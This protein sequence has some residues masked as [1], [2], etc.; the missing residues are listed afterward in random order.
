MTSFQLGVVKDDA[1]STAQTPDGVNIRKINY[2]VLGV[3]KTPIDSE[4]AKQEFRQ[5][6]AANAPPKV[7]AVSTNNGSTILLSTLTSEAGS[8]T[9]V[10]LSATT[11]TTTTAS[12]TTSLEVLL[13]GKLA[14]ANATTQAEILPPAPLANA[15]EGSLLMK[16]YNP[17][18]QDAI[19]QTLQQLWTQAL[20]KLLRQTCG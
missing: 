13:T 5:L 18:D 7:W 17:T 14:P 6:I 11:L 9:T 20:R 1:F 2:Q 4:A 3:A 8:A 15:Y 19:T 16:S 12:T 10:S